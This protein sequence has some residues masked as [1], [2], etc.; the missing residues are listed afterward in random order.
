M[1]P[2]PTSS[3]YVWLDTEFTS[4]EFEQAALLQIAVVLTDTSLRRLA[5]PAFDLNLCIRLEPGTELSPWVR[6]NLPDLILKCR[7]DDAVPMDGL[8]EKLCAYLDQHVGPASD[9]ISRRPIVA[10]S[11]VH[12]DFYLLR[13]L[14][15]G[16]IG[17][18]H[19]RLLDVTAIKLQ[20][21]DFAG[22]EEV[23]KEN[24]EILRANF[25]GAVVSGGPAVH[26]AYYDVQASIAE[27]A[28]YRD[29]FFRAP[30]SVEGADAL[31]V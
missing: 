14:L 7:D 5:D 3:A 11:S 13:R 1:E 16:F 15:P 10:G 20:W 30:D 4:L 6:E 27:L 8:D 31:D 26:D 23:D 22:G 28:Y 18:C 17:R 21:V 9:D 25:P 19:Y 24:P 29:R 12:A 2:R